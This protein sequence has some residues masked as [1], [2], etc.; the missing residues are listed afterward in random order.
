MRFDPEYIDLTSP[1]TMIPAQPPSPLSGHGSVYLAGPVTGLSYGQAR[2]GWRAQ[3]A[4]MLIP[5]IRVLSPMRHENATFSEIAATDASNFKHKAKA[6]YQKDM[7]DIRRADVLFANLLNAGGVCAKGT[8]VE[9]G[10]AWAM[11]KFI[12]AAVEPDS[13][14]DYPFVTEPAGAVVATLE[15]AASVIN[16]LLSEG[17]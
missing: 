2:Y 14:H 6:I 3:F 10:A 5:G 12:V 9:I 1:M 4:H 16:S 7:L 8:L 15:D 11:G 17:I 13:L